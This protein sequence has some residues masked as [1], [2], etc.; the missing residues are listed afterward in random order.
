MPQKAN[1]A[2]VLFTKE[3]THPANS[4][5]A[6]DV[7]RTLEKI[8]NNFLQDVR[9]TGKTQKKNRGV[10]FAILKDPYDEK[11]YVY[12]NIPGADWKNKTC[13]LSK[14]VN[15]G[16]VRVCEIS[17]FS[18]NEEHLRKNVLPLV[19]AVRGMEPGSF[20][21]NK[22]EIDKNKGDIISSTKREIA[23]VGIKALIVSVATGLPPLLKGQSISDTVSS[24]GN[25]IH[26]NPDL[27]KTGAC[28]IGASLFYKVIADWV[29]SDMRKNCSP[30]EA[31]REGF[32]KLSRGKIAIT[33]ENGA[34][35]ALS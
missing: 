10:F 30:D 8:E 22:R 4:K 2:P 19:K 15:I 24:I 6:A 28:L 34:A 16:L 7:T 11:R 31:K 35:L 26:S 12:T 3:P 29:T 5:W 21:T 32:Y 27:S 17:S 18:I 14:D 23:H 1:T 9:A 25:F 33:H 20:E 13:Q